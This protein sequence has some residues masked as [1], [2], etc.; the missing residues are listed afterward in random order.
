MDR[1]YIILEYQ[2]TAEKVQGYLNN[3]RQDGWIVVSVSCPYPNNF[4]V[5][6]DVPS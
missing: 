4:V 5:T 3:R 6:Y 1:K 2:G